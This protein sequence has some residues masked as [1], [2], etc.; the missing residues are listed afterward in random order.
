MPEPTVPTFDHESPFAVSGHPIGVMIC[1]TCHGNLHNGVLYRRE[2]TVQCLHLGWQ[3]ILS[4]KWDDARLW[5]TPAVEPERLESVAGLCRLVWRKFQNERRFPYALR[6]R[7]SHFDA[8]GRLVLGEEARGLTC[9]TFI[10]ALF[11]SFEIELVDES[12]WPVRRE[13]DREFLATVANFARPDHFAV[14]EREVEDG[15]Q[16]VHPDE[17]VG[18]CCC[19]DLP[20][21]FALARPAADAIVLVLDGGV[22]G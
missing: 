3:D 16:R 15:V 8:A 20:A 9:A 14:L 19:D 12:S 22:S 1:R 5:V 6:Y 7:G 21:R 11:K 10:L 17:L 4:D 2:G 13:L 18:A